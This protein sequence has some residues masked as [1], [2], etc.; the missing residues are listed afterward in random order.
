MPG[1]G[2]RATALA[3]VV[4]IAWAASAAARSSVRAPITRGSQYLALGDSVTFG[5]Q[6]PGSGQN[7]DDVASIIGYPELLAGQ[8]HLSVANASCPGETS[9]SMI[10]SAARSFG[11]ED[12][13]NGYPDGYRNTY[14]LHVRYSGSQLSYGLAYLKSHRDVRLVTVQTGLVDLSLCQSQTADGCAS[15]SEIGDV[16]AKLTANLHTILGAIRDVAH[17]TGQLVL[18]NY[19]A[20][21]YGASLENTLVSNIN[22]VL[23]AAVRPYGASVANAYAAFASASASVT[24]NPCA[25]GLLDVVAPGDCGYHA[26]LAGQSVV[27][28]AVRKTIVVGKPA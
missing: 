26:T 28:G 5:F 15:P 27:A 10:D 8:L 17:Y 24:K 11:C 12:G 9:S 3:A 13:I 18:V 2:W 19:Y 16:D 4:L 6:D 20:S 21:D 22:G 25:A 1:L 7:A 14:P 23:A